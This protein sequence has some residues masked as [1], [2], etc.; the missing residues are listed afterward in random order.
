MSN[1]INILTAKPKLTSDAIYSFDEWSCKAIDLIGKTCDEVEHNA[2]TKEILVDSLIELSVLVFNMSLTP[3][4]WAFMNP[5]DTELERRERNLT[6]EQKA[7]FKAFMSPSYV[8]LI[9][10]DHD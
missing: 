1:V 2:I 8:A 9:E 7:F 10:V 5:S 4:E 3:E 6:P